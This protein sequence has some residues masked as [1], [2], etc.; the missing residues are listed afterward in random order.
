MGYKYEE[1]KKMRKLVI[2][3]IVEEMRTRG[4]P[5]ADEDNVSFANA[6]DRLR[7]YLSAGLTS[8]DMIE[9]YK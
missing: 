3:E 1:I 8:N 5:G 4:L 9:G 6:E 7:T 2:N